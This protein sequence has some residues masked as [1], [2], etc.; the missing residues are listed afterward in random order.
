[1]KVVAIGDLHDSPNIRI[2]QD[3]DGLQNT[4]KK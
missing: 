4:L 2:S 3:L 1:M